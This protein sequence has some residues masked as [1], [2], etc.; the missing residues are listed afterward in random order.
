[1]RSF[2]AI[3]LVLLGP[4][5]PAAAG[6]PEAA[7]VRVWAATKL[8]IAGHETTD[9]AG[10][11]WLEVQGR[12][13]TDRGEGVAGVEVRFERGVEAERAA[14][15]GDGSFRV[16]LRA[17]GAP[18]TARFDGG[19]RLRPASVEVP[20]SP[21]APAERS[22]LVF[23]PLLALALALAAGGV[24]LLVRRLP[25][26]LARVLAA[27]RRTG[28]GRRAGASG[29]RDRRPEEARARRLRVID[30]LRFRPIAGACLESVPPAAAVLAVTGDD[31][32]IELSAAPPA[33]VVRSP[34]YVGR[35]LGPAPTATATEGPDAEDEL[36]P[37]LRGRDAVVGW[38][39]RSLGAAGPSAGLPETVGRLASR[40]G[41]PEDVPALAAI[42]YG[43]PRPPDEQARALL[44]R[45]H[46]RAAASA[47]G[48][49]QHRAP[50]PSAV[51]EALATE[52]GATVRAT[53]APRG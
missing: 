36:V 50:E 4:A 33:A 51:V 31:G 19:E 32:T 9:E 23:V 42:C 5:D 34:G 7:R 20:A 47:A 25:G 35:P 15:A 26:L 10:A 41:A 2:P 40:V 21:P 12:L 27:W 17:G 13:V 43:R 30:A 45:L 39:E 24:V 46:A 38:L 16:L 44:V 18:W 48:D 28:A 6:E 52:S 53:S 14:T 3:L 8:E 49:E 11:R 1:M 22:W 37:L 29:G